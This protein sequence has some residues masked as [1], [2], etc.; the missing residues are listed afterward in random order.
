MSVKDK[1]LSIEEFIA[2]KRLSLPAQPGVVAGWNIT[3]RF[4]QQGR[5]DD[6]V[7]LRDQSQ[8]QADAKQYDRLLP[9]EETGKCDE[10]Q[11]PPGLGGPIV[12]TACFPEFDKVD[13]VGDGFQYKQGD[14]PVEMIF[15]QLAIEYPNA[16]A[17]SE[18]EN[19]INIPIPFAQPVVGNA[20]VAGNDPV[21]Y[22]REQAGP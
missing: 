8:Y 10:Q 5:D 18:P 9:G 11:Q 14:D 20:Q 3:F 17:G 16:Y 19:N 1:F 6:P 21:K 4:G 15:H 2:F 13:E 12:G 7:Q 22:I